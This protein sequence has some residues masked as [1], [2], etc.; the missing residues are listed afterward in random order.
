MTSQ[1]IIGMDIGTGSVKIAMSGGV[2]SFPS[3]VARGRKIGVEESDEVVLVG[4]DAVRAADIR[5][6]V[7][8]TPVYR[9]E[10]ASYEDYMMLIEHALKKAARLGRD[11]LHGQTPRYSDLTVIAGIPHSAKNQAR[12]I[13]DAVNKRFAPK[14]FGLMFQAKATLENE[15]ISDG[16]VC[17]I[18]HGTTEIMAVSHGDIS[19]AQTVS[20]GV[21]DIASAIAQSKV[22]Y[23]DW[24]MF[25]GNMQGL[26]ESRRML[27]ARISDSLEK[28]VFDNPEMPVICAG[29]G[30][31]VPKLVSEIKNERIRDIRIAENPVFSNALGM[32][33]RGIRHADSD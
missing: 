15:G 31:L 7:L 14:F 26:A 22:S 11:A 2:F 33:K 32:L 25:S 1:N 30:A 29:G 16:I 5:S 12:K 19:H 24:D 13:K 21:G 18:G 28:V 8:R 17:H 6:M 9:G 4:D 23:L 3:L 10:P 27:A 20:H